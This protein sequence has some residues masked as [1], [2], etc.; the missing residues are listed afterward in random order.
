MARDSPPQ[1][2]KKWKKLRET[3]FQALVFPMG[4]VNDKIFSY[5]LYYYLVYSLIS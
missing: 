5:F 3:V 2:L 1:F 4:L